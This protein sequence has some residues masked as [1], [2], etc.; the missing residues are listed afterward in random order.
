[1][2]VPAFPPFPQ[3]VLS[4]PLVESVV[5]AVIPLVL[6]LLIDIVPPLP[7]FVDP[8]PP[9]ARMLAFKVEV[10]NTT[11]PPLPPEPFGLSA[12]LAFTAYANP[13]NRMLLTV[14]FVNASCVPSCAGVEVAR[15][16]NEEALFDWVLTVILLPL[17]VTPLARTMKHVSKL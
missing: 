1:M 17:M 11:L 16:A 8:L 15:T 12:P 13:A 3:E 9:L 6:V 2:I 4:P 7:P 5:D 10:A 14:R